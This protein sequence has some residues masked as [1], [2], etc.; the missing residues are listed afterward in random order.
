MLFSITNNY[1]R[2]ACRC[3]YAAEKLSLELYLLSQNISY[4]IVR[5][6]SSVL[7]AVSL[8]LVAPFL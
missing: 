5:L 3:V 2:H 1:V 6:L 4:F 7:V 8:L